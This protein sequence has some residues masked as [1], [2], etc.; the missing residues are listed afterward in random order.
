MS[1]E[2]R[3][4]SVNAVE[5]FFEGKDH[6]RLVDV[7]AEQFHA[8]LPPRPK[9]RTHVVHNRDA[10][11]AHLASYAP[12]K[13]RG[14]DDDGEFWMFVVGCADEFAEESVNLRQMTED[15]GDADNRKILGVDDYLAACSAHAV[16]AGDEE[17]ER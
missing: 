7:F 1:D 6:Q 17:L 11:L 15:F 5:I 3:I 12:V 8:S 10:A 13:G 4:Y 16:A 9:L 2:R 14:V